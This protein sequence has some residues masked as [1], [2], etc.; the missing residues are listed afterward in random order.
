MH[1][2]NSE[3]DYIAYSKELRDVS[4]AGCEETRVAALQ[5]IGA[6][7][8]RIAWPTYEEV[9]SM[10]RKK[11]VEY[12]GVG[13]YAI[14]TYTFGFKAR[15]INVDNLNDP[16]YCFQ[17]P[18][19]QMSLESVEIIDYSAACNRTYIRYPLPGETEPGRVQASRLE[20]RFCRD[21]IQRAQQK[22][23]KTNEALGEVPL[24]QQE[25]IVGERC[26]YK[27]KLPAQIVENAECLFVG[28]PVHPVTGKLVVLRN[29]LRP[30]L[31]AGT[32]VV[33]VKAGMKSVAVAIDKV[34]R[35]PP[36]IFLVPKDAMNFV[37]EAD[38]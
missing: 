19:T 5:S 29:N 32:A 31:V 35:L 8:P 23:T 15:P 28:M 6:A 9:S 13:K 7:V 27:P 1:G 26:A 14:Y 22:A 20:A 4:I 30:A 11:T 10:V 33:D 38:R 37:R 17:K 34:N 2:P 16:Q 21:E 36:E 12:F 25:M 24:V 3:A 18:P